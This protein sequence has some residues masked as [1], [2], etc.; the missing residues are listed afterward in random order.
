MG[1]GVWEGV[2]S[3]HPLRR[4]GLVG[5][6]PSPSP[7]FP[8][9][10][11]A[12]CEV[13]RKFGRWHQAS[14]FSGGPS[15]GGGPGVF[16]R[17]LGGTSE[18]LDPLGSPPD[19]FFTQD[20]PP[21]TEMQVREEV[22][23]AWGMGSQWIETTPCGS[24]CG[25]ACKNHRAFLTIFF[26]GGGFKPSSSQRG[27]FFIRP[28]T[29][30]P[31]HEFNRLP[32]VSLLF[33]SIRLTLS[34][35][36]RPFQ[37]RI[38]PNP[39]NWIRVYF[40]PP[41]SRSPAASA[42]RSAKPTSPAHR[43]PLRRQE[44]SPTEFFFVRYYHACGNHWKSCTRS[45]NTEFTANPLFPKVSFLVLPQRLKLTNTKGARKKLRQRRCPFGGCPPVGLRGTTLSM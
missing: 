21:P 10:K 27:S 24:R 13:W 26:Q 1:E 16:K 32:L 44:S 9:R 8:S 6:H 5:A 36:G 34:K 17:S 43:Q 35:C 40:I 2:Q 39:S 18:R 29:F 38:S 30:P 3:P 4:R 15:R 28:A 11:E 22:R 45:P 41:F 25:Y 33:Y 23:G 31:F 37:A 20:P 7:P 12:K 42:S 19:F 14:F